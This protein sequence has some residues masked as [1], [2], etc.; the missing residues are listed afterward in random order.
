MN[1]TVPA[2]IW[3]RHPGLV[4]SNAGAD[5][6]VRLRAALLRPRFDTLLDLA[7]HFGLP[8]LRKEWA[9]LAEEDS[10]EIRRAQP[11]VERI[12]RN[13]EEGFGRAAAGN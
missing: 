11:C 4:W 1:G 6:G 7:L 10:P 13:I 12:L 5:D 9:W 2:Q 3:Q 8:R